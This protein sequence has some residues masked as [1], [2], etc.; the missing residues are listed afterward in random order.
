MGIGITVPH[1]IFPSSPFFLAI[2]ESYEYAEE[3]GTSLVLL[4]SVLI[5][6]KHATEPWQQVFLSD[7][8]VYYFTAPGGFESSCRIIWRTQ[9]KFILQTP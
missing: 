2:Q 7:S 9:G 5:V 8:N 4:I 1:G 6:D 3:Q